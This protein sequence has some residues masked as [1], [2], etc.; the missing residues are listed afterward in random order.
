MLDL[1]DKAVQNLM[2]LAAHA[3]SG[4]VYAAE[5]EAMAELWADVSQAKAYLISRKEAAQAKAPASEP[6]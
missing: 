5:P 2:I 3:L 6:G 1:S 4:K